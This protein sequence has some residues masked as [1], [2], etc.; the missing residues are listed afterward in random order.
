MSS[1]FST[2]NWLLNIICLNLAEAKLKEKWERL[3]RDWDLAR[4]NHLL[5][6]PRAQCWLSVEVSTISLWLH[7]D[8]TG[9][10]KCHLEHVLY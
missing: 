9:A 3:Q 8:Q 2:S 6:K 4:K 5:W 10:D 1:I 7:R